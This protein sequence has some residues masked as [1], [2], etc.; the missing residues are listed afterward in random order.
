MKKKTQ[1]EK[2]QDAFI[3]NDGYLISDGFFPRIAYKKAI[4]RIIK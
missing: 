3:D 1:F 4:N 2:D